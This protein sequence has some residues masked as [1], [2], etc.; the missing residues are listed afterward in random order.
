MPLIVADLKRLLSQH[1]HILDDERKCFVTRRV[2]AGR[3]QILLF[4]RPICSSVKITMLIF[5]NIFMPFSRTDVTSSQHKTQTN[6]KI[7]QSKEELNLSKEPQQES[8]ELSAI[9][10]AI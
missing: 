7:V 8:A 4:R 2:V 1:L 9:L 5:P 6:K 10:R 3:E